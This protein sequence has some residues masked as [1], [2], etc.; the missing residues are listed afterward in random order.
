MSKEEKQVHTFIKHIHANINS[1]EKELKA[2]TKTYSPDHIHELRISIRRLVA[3]LHL[4]GNIIEYKEN[5]NLIKELKIIMKAL[6]KTRDM[7]VQIEYFRQLQIE[8]KNLDLL[9]NEL[10]EKRNILQKKAKKYLK[11]MDTSA[12]KKLL[13]NLE[14]ALKKNTKYIKEEKLRKNLRTTYTK[15][16]ESRKKVNE[17][18]P[19]T[20][21]KL[22]IIFKRFRYSSELIANIISISEEELEAMKVFQKRL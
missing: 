8:Y 4:I 21:H 6:N 11:N 1:F 16:L 3:T 2:S 9:I 14:K 13:K 10:S 7:D 17:D 19:E 20:I 18:K 15:V 12:I 22:R 5:K